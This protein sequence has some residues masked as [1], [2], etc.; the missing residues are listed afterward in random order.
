M[1]PSAATQGLSNGACCS[2][3]IAILSIVQ[4]RSRHI[5]EDSIGPLRLD[6]PLRALKL[7]CPQVAT[8]SYSGEE[9]DNPGVVFQFYRL[10]V[11]G[12]QIRGFHSFG[13][14]LQTFGIVSGENGM[15]FGVPLSARWKEFKH[16][17][18]SMIARAEKC[19]DKRAKHNRHVLRSSPCA[20]LNLEA[21][22]ESVSTLNP[23]T[24][25]GSQRDT[26]FESDHP[27]CAR[28]WLGLLAAL[29]LF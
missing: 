20:L 25:P 7:V 23:S 26:G 10:K 28:S 11:D 19:I 2:W 24:L 17:V 4:S 15:L 8:T 16:N 29:N 21:P 3:N 22:P 27:V 12:I 14:Y 18:G 1:S 5:S 9:S 6:L 13:V